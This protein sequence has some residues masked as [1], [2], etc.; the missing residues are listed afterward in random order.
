MTCE[1]TRDHFIAVILKSFLF[2]QKGL[3]A[4]QVL[5]SCKWNH[6]MFVLLCMIY[7]I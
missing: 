3:S 1:I 4:E 7:F 5:P 6:T 2:T